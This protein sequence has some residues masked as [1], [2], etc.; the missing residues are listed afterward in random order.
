MYNYQLF[1]N[2]LFQSDMA[3]LEIFN[4]LIVFYQYQCRFYIPG[5]CILISFRCI[6]MI[7]WQVYEKADFENTFYRL[8]QSFYV[9]T[10]Y[11]L[12]YAALQVRYLQNL[13]CTR[14]LLIYSFCSAEPATSSRIYLSGCLDILCLFAADV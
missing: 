12:W 4:C 1:Q 9:Y 5:F 7:L 8:F 14:L 11:F 13:D 6:L 3:G 10:V 2:L